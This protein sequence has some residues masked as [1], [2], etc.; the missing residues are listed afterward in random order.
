EVGDATVL[1][2]IGVRAGEHMDPVGVLGV[3]RPDLLAVDDEVVAV[4]HGAGLQAGEV[5]AGARLG[6]ALAPEH[7]GACD[8]R[9]EAL[10]LLLVAVHHDAGA[11]HVDPLPAAAGRAVIGALLAE[12][13]L[14]DVA[15]AGAAVLFG[16]GHRQPATLG[17]LL[18]EGAHARELVVALGRD[19]ADRIAHAPVLADEAA[20]LA[21][22]RLVL[23]GKCELH[24]LPPSALCAAGPAFR[25]SSS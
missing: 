14:A 1:R 7:V 10:L 13:H 23:F 12:D 2:R 20:H 18:L 6:E 8:R 5:G 4:G 9:Q 11:D 17:Q 3:A 22:E 24:G 25:P 15:G 21:A 16:P 19:A